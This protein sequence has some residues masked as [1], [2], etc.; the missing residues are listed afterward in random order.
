[1]NDYSIWCVFPTG[2]FQYFIT[3][4]DET[5]EEHN[6]LLAFKI[7]LESVI[8][9]EYDIDQIADIEFGFGNHE[10]HDMLAKRA[11]GL[12]SGNQD[13]VQEKEKE[14]TDYKNKHIERLMTPIYAHI[15]FSTIKD[16]ET[17]LSS[18][19]LVLKS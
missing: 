19:K 14:M 13:C 6:N 7:M 16:A 17:V 5:T 3:E 9:E 18:K 2:L 11:D 15:T 12:K 8:K 4:Y 10:L 1:M